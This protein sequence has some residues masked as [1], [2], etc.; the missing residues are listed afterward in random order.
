MVEIEFHTDIYVWWKE[1]CVLKLQ[2]Q[3][4]RTGFKIISLV[5]WGIVS[6]KTLNINSLETV[7]E[8]TSLSYNR[9]RELSGVRAVMQNE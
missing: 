3:V 2:L 7:F 8:M 5:K 6:S 9:G 1:T 4:S